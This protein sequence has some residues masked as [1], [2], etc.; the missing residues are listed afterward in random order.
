MKPG[1]DWKEQI[2]KWEWKQW[3]TRKRFSK[4]MANR[5]DTASLMRELEIIEA[6]LKR[7]DEMNSL[8]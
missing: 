6:H 5:E 8:R 1:I 4:A 3:N 2:R 7:L